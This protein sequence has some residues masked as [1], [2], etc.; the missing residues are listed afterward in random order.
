MMILKG[1]G[2]MNVM[3]NCLKSL[4]LNNP[5]AA[6]IL[7]AAL[8][9]ADPAVAVTDG[10]R[11]LQSDGTLTNCR[12]I[13]VV[14]MGKAS[15]P[16][17]Q[18]ACAVLGRQVA[19]GLA[20]GKNLPDDSE[21]QLPGLTV[22]SG[23][24]P[25]PDV[26]SVT[27]GNLVI[28]FIEANK[29]LDAFLFLISGGASALVTRPTEGIS[30]AD[31]KITTSL[32]LGCGATIDE[33]NTVRKHLD[34][35]KGG[36]LAALAAPVPCITLVLSDVPGDRL[37][38]IASG[39]TVPDLT[40]FKD[41]V[42]VF[43]KYSL[44]ESVPPSVKSH[45]MAGCHGS[46]PETPKPGDPMFLNSKVMIVGS[47]EK[48]I[49]AAVKEAELQG[50]RTERLKPT[51]SGEAADNGRRLGSFLA[52]QA[53]TA[54]PGERCCWIG[55]GET[56][57]TLGNGPAGKGGRNQELAL[58][59]VHVLAG[60]KRVVLITFATDGDD[61]MSPAA[62][63]IV[64]GETGLLAL[65]KRMDAADYL[66]RHDSYTFFEAINSAIVTGP[67]GTNVNDLIFLMID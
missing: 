31:M 27:A 45:L 22:I 34:T 25:V 2:R 12:R 67:T 18:A 37:D 21:K 30:L 26:R 20:I 3:N 54:P 41:A 43:D 16:M 9:A 40:T 28:Q 8:I 44:L 53:M 6:R 61:G 66:S 15:I 63:A 10:L 64:T 7:Q 47:L 24:H 55:G 48:S 49:E 32:L 60:L 39:P 4:E 11:A 58:A 19:G 23:A 1:H 65:Q 5:A 29:E 46:I 51:I 33:I 42:D 52:E 57:V 59:A 35:V 62:G 56:T 13:G 14:A 36:G 38:M 50:Y 17:A